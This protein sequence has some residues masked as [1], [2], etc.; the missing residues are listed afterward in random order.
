MHRIPDSLHSTLFDI[1]ERLALI[2]ERR[3]SLGEYRI[4]RITDLSGDECLLLADEGF[5]DIKRGWVRLTEKGQDY[6]ASYLGET[7]T[8][9]HLRGLVKEAERLSA[10]AYDRVSAGRSA[11]RT[12]PDSEQVKRDRQ[13]AED[14]TIDMWR[15]MREIS[16]LFRWEK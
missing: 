13:L 16:K 12:H 2:A 11:V 7:T 8:L 10:E 4:L 9:N 6:L 3:E 14:Y 1:G 5:I 15:Y